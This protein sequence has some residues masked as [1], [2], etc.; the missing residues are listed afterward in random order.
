MPDRSIGALQRGGRWGGLCPPERE[1]PLA[2]R[3]PASGYPS[4]P[5]E[6]FDARQV[7]RGPSAWGA[8]GGALPPPSK[9]TTARRPFAGERLSKWA[10]RGLRCQT[11]RSGP[12]SVGG[13]GGLCPPQREQPLA[14]RS[15]ASGYPSGP[16]EA[17]DARQV[18]RGP[19]AWGA[20]GGSAPP[21]SHARPYTQIL[22]ADRAAV[23][24]RRSGAT[25]SLITPATFAFS[26]SL[27]SPAMR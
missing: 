19:S 3:S 17:F 10:G 13:G 2:D 7:D 1:Q 21:H 11:G 15:P 4:G 25:A 6:A 14:D 5:V 22:R 23:V 24:R 12:F 8:V 9:R 27:K 16:V 20:V 18:D 26:A